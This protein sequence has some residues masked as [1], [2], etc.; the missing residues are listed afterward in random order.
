MWNRVRE[1]VKASG[2]RAVNGRVGPGVF[3]AARPAGWWRDDYVEQLRNY[4]SW[5]YAAVTCPGSLVPGPD[6]GRGGV[7]IAQVL[8]DKG[9]LPGC[10]PAS[11][12]RRRA[13]AGGPGTTDGLADV[14]E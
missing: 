8:A 1:W 5:V 4:Q 14:V 10:E 6:G 7:Q 9:P 12:H 13:Y 3:P 11:R 2:P